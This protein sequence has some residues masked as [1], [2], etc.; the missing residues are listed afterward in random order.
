MRAPELP[1][2]VVWCNTQVPH[3]IERDLRGC[4]G[5]LWFSSAASIHCRGALQ[6]LQTLALRFAGRQ[7][8]MLGLLSSEHSAEQDPELAALLLAQLGVQHPFGID[9]GGAARRL[10]G[11]EA[12]PTL[13]LLDP[14]GTIRYRGAGEPDPGRMA[15]AIEALLYEGFAAGTLRAAMAPVELEAVPASPDGLR[16]PSGIAHD[17]IRDLLWIADSGN[18]RIVAV[19]S[20]SG[21]MVAVFGTGMPGAGDGTATEA[22]FCSPRGLALLAGA[23]YVAD[24]ANHCVRRIDPDSG[25]VTTVVGRGEPTFDL[26]GGNHGRD[27][28]LCW[29]LALAADGPELWL[30]NAGTH[31]IWRVDPAL[32]I[33]LPCAGTGSH[34]HGDGDAQIAGLAHPCALVRQR[35]ALLFLDAETG[36]LRELAL[37]GMRVGTRLRGRFEFPRGLALAGDRVYVADA[38]RSEVVACDGA[39]GAALLSAA[40]GL[41]GP[42]ALATDGTTLWIADALAHAIHAHD[43]EHGT[44][45]RLTLSGLPAARPRH[46]GRATLRADAEVELRLT[47]PL[48]AAARFADG[49]PPQVALHNTRGRPLWA[50]LQLTADLAQE[51][52]VLRGLPTGAAGPGTIA[53]RVLYAT[54]HESVTLLHRQVFEAELELELTA[55]G[56]LRAEC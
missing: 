32:G 3:S 35:D 31:Q 21:R 38:W 40:D 11:C 10:F 9:R 26:L 39:Q 36:S 2:E 46:R 27:Q 53:A 50:P 17:A 12:L 51:Q 49:V 41:L 24:S 33:A 43:L 5:V 15:A 28:G 42:E 47:L 30:A 6:V 52:A 25:I 34:G 37:D 48:P 29:P 1:D 19:H 16:F 45:T 54:Q 56:P 13:L 44:T 55:D 20:R 18:H 23:V 14:E 22:T 4:V 7:V 8:A